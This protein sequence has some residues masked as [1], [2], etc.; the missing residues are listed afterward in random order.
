MRA[1]NL[2][3]SG[4]PALTLR[5]PA[6]AQKDKCKLKDGCD[7][8]R[9]ILTLTI[10]GMFQKRTRSTSNRTDTDPIRTP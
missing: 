1:N 10:G 9:G 7:R 5:G 4:K 2:P 8:D 3:I 6:T